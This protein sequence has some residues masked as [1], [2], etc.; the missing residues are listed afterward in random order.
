[1]TIIGS[2]TLS[3]SLLYIYKGHIGIYYQYG[4]LS[5]FLMLI[6]LKLGHLNVGMTPW[7]PLSGIWGVWAIAAATGPLS[8]IFG[9]EPKPFGTFR[10][11]VA[12]GSAGDGRGGDSAG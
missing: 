3:D 12:L 2:Y 8:G 1:V 10:L 7:K 6:L 4:P 9:C 11:G 5:A